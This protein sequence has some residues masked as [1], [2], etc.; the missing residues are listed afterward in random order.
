MF[1]ADLLKDQVVVVTGGGSGLGRAMALYFTGLGAKTVVAGR[2][3]EPLAETVQMVEAKGG[4]ALA[5]PTDVRDPEQVQQLVKVTLD[6]FGR[7]DVLINN[8]A[9]NFICR[10]E[11]L[12]INGWKAVV[13][14]VLNGTFYCSRFFGEQ[15][16]RQQYGR[17]VNI[18]APYA[19]TGNPGTIHSA[20]AKA[21][22]L[23][24]T[25]TLAVEWARHQIRVNAIAPGAVDTDGA[26][27]R[28]WAE[29]AAVETMLKNNPTH[30]FGTAEEIAQAAAYLISPMA[31]FVNGACLTV[32]GGAWLNRPMFDLDAMLAQA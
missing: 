30:R 17:M 14:I 8:A 6:R 32:D 28:L 29:P 15:M 23:A 7:S 20:C 9:G 16:I 5:V 3:P 24:M 21:G 26:G 4:Q 11:N 1:Q 10:A 18:I 27:S 25:Q 31:D 22:V 13:D 2:R 12:S 19:W